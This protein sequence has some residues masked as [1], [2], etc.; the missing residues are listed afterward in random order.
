VLAAF[1]RM[2]HLAWCD[3]A[4]A[5]RLVLADKALWGETRPA[6]PG[7]AEAVTLGFQ[8]IHTV[9]MAAALDRAVARALAGVRS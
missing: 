2:K 3:P 5:V 6:V 7:L 4:Q 1:A 9:G 8:E